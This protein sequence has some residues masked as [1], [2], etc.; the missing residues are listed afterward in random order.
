MAHW[1]ELLQGNLKGS[2]TKVVINK[3][4]NIPKTEMS[5]IAFMT[6]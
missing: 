2:M 4:W 6:K 3:N 1:L 5:P